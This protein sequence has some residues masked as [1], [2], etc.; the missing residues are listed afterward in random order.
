MMPNT[1][2]ALARRRLLGGACAALAL[3]LA[4][5]A[6]FGDRAPRVTVA[7]VEPASGQGLEMRFNLVLRV[8]NPG[9]APLTFDGVALDL[10]LNGDRFASGVSDVRGSVPR[11]GETTVTVPVSVSALSAVRQILGLVDGRGATG[12]PYVLRGRL[13]G[14]TFGTTRFTDRGRLDLPGFGSR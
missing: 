6:T 1:V 3:S 9:D 10:D 14:G 11:F 8:Q 5:C 2:P 7:G 12:V 4:G 13:A